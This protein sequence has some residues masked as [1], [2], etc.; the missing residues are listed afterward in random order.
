MVPFK[1]GYGETYRDNALVAMLKAGWLPKKYND[2]IAYLYERENKY[3]IAW[4]TSNG[5]KRDCIKNGII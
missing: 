1:Y 3:P 2:K 5:L 4:N